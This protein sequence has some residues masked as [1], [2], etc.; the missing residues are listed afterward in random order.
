MF[1]T[2]PLSLNPVMRNMSSVLSLSTEPS[3]SAA[4]IPLPSS[5]PHACGTS[6]GCS[7]VISCHPEL[8]TVHLSSQTRCPSPHPLSLPPLRTLTPQSSSPS[9]L[10][11][12][13]QR[14]SP[15]AR[16]HAAPAQ[17]LRWQRQSPSPQPPELPVPR[18][19]QPQKQLPALQQ[20]G[21][22]QVVAAVVQLLAVQVEHLRGVHWAQRSQ[23]LTSR[24]SQPHG[25]VGQQ[26]GEAAHPAALPP[27]M[28][29]IMSGEQRLSSPPW[30]LVLVPQSQQ[31]AGPSLASPWP[32]PRQLSLR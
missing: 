22:L 23:G 24:Q 4:C 30:P 20:Q 3:R 8:Q 26:P 6:H 12:S 1:L 31:L 28:W 13:Y 11:S 7:C 10:P 27:C 18:Q 9:Q 5:Q 21:Q 17:L 32:L 15:A 2:L 19:T 14:A 29:M 16:G 25:E